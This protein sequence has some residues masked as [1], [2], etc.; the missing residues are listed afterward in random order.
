MSFNYFINAVAI[1]HTE[2][3]TS[4]RN[5]TFGWVGFRT[6]SVYFTP[7]NDD[8]ICDLLY[9]A[10]TF[11]L[12]MFSISILLRFIHCKYWNFP[13]WWNGR[14]QWFLNQFCMIILCT[15]LS[16]Q[17]TLNEKIF[18]YC[19]GLLKIQNVRWRIFYAPLQGR[20]TWILLIAA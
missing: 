8:K 16:F 18:S 6:Y 10:E 7:I 9:L 12:T 1:S 20:P 13:V 2:P 15:S 14:Y 19:I 4:F 5:Q 11:I 17:Q 3:Y